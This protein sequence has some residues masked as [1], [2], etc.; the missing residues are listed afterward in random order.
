MGPDIPAADGV[1]CRWCGEHEP[2][3]LICPYVKALEFDSASGLIIT[4]VE[5]LTPADWGQRR[6]SD[7]EA[8]APSYPRLGDKDA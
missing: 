5:F 3:G 7:D 6:Q 8:P 2:R 1:T 4:R